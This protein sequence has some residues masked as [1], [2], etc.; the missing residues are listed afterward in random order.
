MADA[1]RERDK[2]ETELLAVKKDYK[3]RIDLSAPRLRKRQRNTVPAN[4]L[5]PSPATA[6][7][8]GRRW[9][10]YGAIP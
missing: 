10:S 8:I 2:L 9:R 3:A 1:L 6:L 4:G 7:K 5:K